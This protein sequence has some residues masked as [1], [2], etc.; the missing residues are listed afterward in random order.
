MPESYSEFPL[1]IKALDRLG[2]VLDRLSAKLA[3]DERDRLAGLEARERL[4][5]ADS[6]AERAEERL[7]AAITRLRLLLGDR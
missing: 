7:D 6:I 4:G 2:E 3:E 1:T 5:E